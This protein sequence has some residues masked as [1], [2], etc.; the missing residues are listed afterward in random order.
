M[1]EIIFNDYNELIQKTDM[2]N[3]KRKVLS[4]AVTLFAKQGFMGTSTVQIAELSGMSEGT[5]FKY[6]K[7]KQNLLE[8]ILNP[9]IQNI[10]PKHVIDFMENQIPEHVSI[11]KLIKSVVKNRLNFAL[12]NRDIVQILVGELMINEHLLNEVK[13]QILPMMQQVFEKLTQQMGAD[14]LDVDNLARLFLGQIFYEFLRITKFKP[15][16]TIDV[17]QVAETIA[18]N[19]LKVAR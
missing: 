8:A 9:L 12:T 2:P 18:N 13:A 19:I 1:S 5:I 14:K 3:G 17:D 4:A 7:T 11:E 6:F 15:D 16:T 10:V